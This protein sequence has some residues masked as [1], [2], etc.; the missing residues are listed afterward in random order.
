M[1]LTLT[2]RELTF[3]TGLLK[4]AS[5]SGG[6]SE[7]AIVHRLGIKLAKA[8]I[9]AGFAPSFTGAIGA[10][11]DRGDR[12]DSEGDNMPA[13]SNSQL[14]ANNLLLASIKGETISDDDREWYYLETGNRL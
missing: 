10:M 3:L 9:S 6:G 7:I 13:L 2:T 11:Q 12:G 1:R 14:R 4:T 5:L 8:G